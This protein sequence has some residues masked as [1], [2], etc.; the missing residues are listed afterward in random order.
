[1][2]VV[3]PAGVLLDGVEERVDVVV[4]AA[5]QPDDE[6]LVVVVVPRQ[7]AVD[8]VAVDRDVVGLLVDRGD[9]GQLDLGVGRLVAE[10]VDEL[11][12]V[13]AEALL[14]GWDRVG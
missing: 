11:T 2:G 6:A 10:D 7:H 1:M 13:H 8:R 4:L 9:D 12:D 3:V 14:V 5:D